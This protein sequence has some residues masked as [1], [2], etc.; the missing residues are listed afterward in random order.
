MQSHDYV[1]GVSG[2]KFDEK[3]GE[4]DIGSPG[5]NV[6]GLPPKSHFVTVKVGEWSERDIP[7][8]ALERYRFIGQQLFIVSPEHRESAEFSTEDHSCDGDG[9]DIRTTLTYTRPET[10][11]EARA[12]VERAKVAGTRVIHKNGCMTIIQDGVVRVRIGDLS[13]PFI[14]E[15]DQVLISETAVDDGVVHNAKLGPT[16]SVGMAVNEEGQYVASGIGLGL[17]LGGVMTYLDKCA[18]KKEQP[19]SEIEQAIADG[20]V[21]KV[22]DLIAGTI[23]ETELCEALKAPLKS[24]TAIRDVI[25]DELRPGGLLHRR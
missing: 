8:N 6:D 3:T 4:L 12:R 13:R 20:D 1:P 24:A 23:S 16:W 25:R 22:M 5:I 17:S 18:V 21:Q 7:A 19:K 9:S 2:W 10:T 15:G 11:E 14:V